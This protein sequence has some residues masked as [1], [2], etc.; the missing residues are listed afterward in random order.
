MHFQTLES[1][2]L[3]PSLYYFFHL[4]TRSNEI[5]GVLDK[6][7]FASENGLVSM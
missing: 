5:S 1:I 3:F 2:N 6:H 4:E 7:E